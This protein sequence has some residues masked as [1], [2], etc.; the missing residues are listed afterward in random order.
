MIWKICEKILKYIFP[1]LFSK[2]PWQM[3]VTNSVSKPLNTY[4]PITHNPKSNLAS[5][6]IWPKY[7]QFMPTNIITKFDDNMMKSIS[8]NKLECNPFDD[9]CYLLTMAAAMNML[10]PF[11]LLTYFHK[12][13]VKDR[14]KWGVK[15]HPLHHLPIFISD[16][17]R[18]SE[19]SSLTLYITYLFS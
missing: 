14:V 11:T 10:S 8:L 3:C 15:S 4:Q 9:T 6:K 19:G 1:Q 17:L 7:Y 2:H 12:W 16:L 18:S 5:Y 13:F